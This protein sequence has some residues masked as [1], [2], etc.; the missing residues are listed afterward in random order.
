MTTELSFLIE[1]LLKHKLQP[2]TRDLVAERV[3]EVEG[4]LSDSSF[5]LRPLDESRMHYPVAQSQPASKQAPSTLAA[6]AR[7]EAM[8]LV[9]VPTPEAAPVPGVAV[10][11]T[12]QAQ[13]AIS[14]RN[15]AI[16][17]SLA[18]KIDKTTGRPRKF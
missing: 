5:V 18:G 16:R 10:A 14:S 9:A 15:Q 11:Q 4:K 3:K 6:M 12:P 8:G 1:L 2:A 7:H 13:A 17:E